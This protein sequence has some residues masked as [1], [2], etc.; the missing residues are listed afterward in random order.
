MPNGQFLTLFHDTQ[1]ALGG[2]ISVIPSLLPGKGTG[3]LR[4]CMG[5]MALTSAAKKDHSPT[6]MKQ[7]GI[8]LYMAALVEVRRALSTRRKPDIELL[9]ASR[10]FSLYEVGSLSILCESALMP[11]QGLHGGDSGDEQAQYNS[12]KAH[13]TGDLALI[14]AQSP[15]RFATG[16]A[17]RL[18]V[19][20]R[21]NNVHVSVIPNV[22]WATLVLTFGQAMCA[23]TTRKRIFLSDPAW[24]TVPWSQY[25][26]TRKDLLVDILLEIPSLYESVDR[27]DLQDETT[28]FKQ[29]HSVVKSISI[30]TDRLNDWK[31]KYA[32]TT[33]EIPYSSPGEQSQTSG[34]IAADIIADAHIM[35]TYWASC[36]LVYDLLQTVSGGECEF[37]G[38]DPDECCRSI[39]LCLPIF[40]H[41]S[42]GMFRHHLLPFPLM[43]AARYLQMVQPMRLQEEWAHLQFLSEHSAVTSIRQFLSSMQ[44]HVAK[45]LSEDEGQNQ[46]KQKTSK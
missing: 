19:D 21:W 33:S 31:E 45:I 24:M 8:K 23:L 39:T 16:P 27:M 32:S 7:Q 34:N 26:K 14:A 28:Q 41:P 42:T 3:L 22:A 1:R 43:V 15:S 12:W 44:P 9:A 30:L 2:S 38:D 20:G 10:V 46:P 6:W 4:M 29:R 36:I 11:T 17:H 13:H 25:P 35:T 18:F 37:T 40:L 5:A